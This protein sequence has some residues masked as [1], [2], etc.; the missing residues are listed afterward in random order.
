MSGITIEIDFGNAAFD[1][2][3]LG[4]E[5]SRI[6]RAVSNRYYD[7]SR[8]E[9][10]D[11]DQE[12]PLKDINGNTVGRVYIEV[13]DENEDEDDELRPIYERIFKQ[14]PERGHLA[15]F[16]EEHL[17][18]Q[19]YELETEDTLLDAL[20][21]NIRDGSTDIEEFEAFMESMNSAP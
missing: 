8:Q 14:A 9:I 1:G 7:M 3:E 17:G 18:M 19:V 5:L 6:L 13:E 11:D 10:Q 21:E 15:K 16:L 4:I 2:D 12:Y 20:A